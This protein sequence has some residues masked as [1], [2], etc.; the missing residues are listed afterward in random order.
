MAASSQGFKSSLSLRLGL[1]PSSL[2]RSKDPFHG[3]RVSNSFRPSVR[4]QQSGGWEG[5]SPTPGG[6][7]AAGGSGCTRI[8]SRVL[9][10]LA[11]PEEKEVPCLKRQM[12]TPSLAEA[13]AGSVHGVLPRLH[14]RAANGAW[15]QTDG[16]L[17][18]QPSSG[19]TSQWLFLVV[20]CFGR[21]HA[22]LAA[23]V[24][25]ASKTGTGAGPVWVWRKFSLKLNQICKC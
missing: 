16:P 21:T 2:P 13:T 15:K 7:G 1:A 19:E 24:T 14:S 25:K 11:L 8:L 18:H 22:S 12:H 23:C 9:G 20:L 6:S 17:P 3:A 4:K 5:R 10:A